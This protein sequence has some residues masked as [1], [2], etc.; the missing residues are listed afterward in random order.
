MDIY[1]PSEGCFSDVRGPFR[2]KNPK[3]IHKNISCE[4]CSHFWDIFSKKHT[5]FQLHIYIR[6]KTRNPNIIFKISIYNTNY[7]KN[8]KIYTNIS[9][10]NRKFRKIN[11]TQKIN[12]LLYKKSIIHIL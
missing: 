10:K 5:F 8:T 9:K 2:T 12:V 4:D 3:N 6:K 11:K 7:T 1:Y